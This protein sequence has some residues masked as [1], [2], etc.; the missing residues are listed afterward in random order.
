MQIRPTSHAINTQAVN[1]QTNTATQSTTND[2]A[3]APVD[4]LD[5]SIEAQSMSGT[6]ATTSIRAD[7][8]AELRAE[9]A[10][11]QYDTNERLD[12]AMAR[13]LDVIG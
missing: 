4:Q 6:D 9:I 8:V 2:V 1:L 7:R 3:N 11:G 13:M 12:A 5:I 10:A